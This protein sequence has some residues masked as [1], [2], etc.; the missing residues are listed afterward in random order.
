MVTEI[1]CIIDR[2][3]SMESIA[4]DAV[5]GFNSFLESQKAL[6]GEA[7]LT[8][9]LFYHELLF[10][11]DSVELERVEPLDRQTFVPR[12]STALFDAIGPEAT[13]GL[14]L[15]IS[16]LW[17][18]EPIAIRLLDSTPAM[19][20][21]LRTTTAPTILEAGMKDNVIPGRARA[22]VNFRILPG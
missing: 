18:F 20:A 19:A 4:D 2:S 6:P 16:N 10:V 21:L 5:G 8:L 11:H 17:L 15:V 13:F 14:R 1:V 22:V 9:V 7:R 3:G 12:G